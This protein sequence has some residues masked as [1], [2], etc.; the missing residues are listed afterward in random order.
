[1]LDD[2]LL[3][4]AQVTGTPLSCLLIPTR[5]AGDGKIGMARNPLRL[6]IRLHR[7]VVYNVGWQVYAS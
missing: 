4:S 2:K 3:C 1:M 5:A 6:P 7:D